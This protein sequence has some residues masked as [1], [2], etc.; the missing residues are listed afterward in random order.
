MEFEVY[1][2]VFMS[3]DEKKK[4]T[5]ICQA[6]ELNLVNIEVCVCSH[7]LITDNASSSSN[8]I[9][10]PIGISEILKFMSGM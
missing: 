5:Y 1:E 8:P 7:E 9:V 3:S 10:V 2:N 6:N 4:K